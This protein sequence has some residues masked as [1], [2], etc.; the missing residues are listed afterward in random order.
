MVVVLRAERGMDVMNSLSVSR[1]RPIITVAISSGHDS[2]DADLDR[3]QQFVLDGFQSKREEEIST[4]ERYGGNLI[5]F[6]HLAELMMTFKIDFSTVVPH[7]Q[8]PVKVLV[9]P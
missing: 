4:I 8:I 9:D 2:F 6:Q 3:G 7:S 1:T 5:S